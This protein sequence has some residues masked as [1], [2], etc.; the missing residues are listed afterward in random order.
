MKGLAF[1]GN[2]GKSG[3][4]LPLHRK[5]TG[6]AGQPASQHS[7]LPSLGLKTSRVAASAA[8]DSPFPKVMPA[9]DGYFIL[10]VG[11]DPTFQRFLAVA[12]KAGRMDEI[13]R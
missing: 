13:S 3:E 2:A 6:A 10:A 1:P 7:S 4:Q 11:N 8:P 9:S 5:A 12:D